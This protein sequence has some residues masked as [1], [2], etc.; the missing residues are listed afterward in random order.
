MASSRFLAARLP[1]FRHDAEF[2][3]PVE[4][5]TE[6]LAAFMQISAAFNRRESASVPEETAFFRTKIQQMNSFADVIPAHSEMPSTDIN[7]F[8]QFLLPGANDFKSLEDNGAVAVFVVFVAIR[9]NQGNGIGF[10]VIRFW[11]CGGRARTG[12][13]GKR[14]QGQ[15]TKQKKNL[16][17]FQD[18]SSIFNGSQ[19]THPNEDGMA[20]ARH[21]ATD[22]QFSKVK[23]LANSPFFQPNQ[24]MSA[25]SAEK[26]DCRANRKDNPVAA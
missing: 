4:V 26:T 24:K 21:P 1:C 5:L 18:I 2:F 17:V 11:G 7:P 14:Q 22:T 8:G 10:C 25:A 9:A 23:N 12:P 13:C 16:S 20:P 15:Q 6:T 19:I 3:Q